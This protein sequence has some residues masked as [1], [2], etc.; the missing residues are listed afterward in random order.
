ME[1]LKQIDELMSLRAKSRNMSNEE[2]RLL[3]RIQY[4]IRQRSIIDERIETLEERRYREQRR[5][6][7]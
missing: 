7:I 3:L 5:N 1:N 2:D 6:R 4:L